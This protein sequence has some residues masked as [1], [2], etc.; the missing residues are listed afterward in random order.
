[1]QWVIMDVPHRHP[2]VTLKIKFL[3]TRLETVMTPIQ[4]KSVIKH[5]SIWSIEIGPEKQFHLE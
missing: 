3:D 2:T 5:F 1:M 4:L